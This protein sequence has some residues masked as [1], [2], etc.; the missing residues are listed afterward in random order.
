MI[1]LKNKVALI[2]GSSRGIGRGLALKYAEHGAKVIIT[3]HQNEEAGLAV[4]NEINRKGGEGICCRLDVSKQKS[5]KALFEKITEAYNTL[6]ILVN[7]AA[8]LEQKPCE[9]ITVDEWDEMF[10]VDCRGVFLCCQKAVEI[11]QKNEFGRI[12]NMT[13]IGGQWGGNLAVHYS[14]AK[15]AVISITRSFA[16]IYSEYNITSNAISPGLVETDMSRKETATREGMKKI[17][18]IPIKRMATIDEISK[19][20]LFLASEM[21]TYITGQTINVN[22]G[23]YFG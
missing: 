19:V 5:I 23:M 18:A 16:R 10:A 12:I 9:L 15:A 20:A 1:T 21:S 17:E 22:G 8:I 7:N 4:L 3:Y 2:T 14:A 13:S 6:D 11:M